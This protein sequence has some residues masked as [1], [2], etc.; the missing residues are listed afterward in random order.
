MKGL[1]RKHKKRELAVLLLLVL[2][3]L[4]AVIATFIIVY[5]MD[6]LNDITSDAIGP[7]TVPLEV[8]TQ[9]AP[10]EDGSRRAYV[11][12]AVVIEL[13]SRRELRDINNYA[14]R[15]KA[16]ISHTINEV[17][18]EL[19]IDSTYLEVL[20]R[21]MIDRFESELAITPKNIFYDKIIVQ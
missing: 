7:Y 16:I 5:A 6:Q 19:L 17:S 14:E 21:D 18:A 12:I 15:S 10:P 1:T 2:I 3:A 8:L 13:E 20:K 11:K 9:A 4:A